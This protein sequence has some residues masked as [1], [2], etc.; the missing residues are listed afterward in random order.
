MFSFLLNPRFEFEE[1]QRLYQLMM[2]SQYFGD[3]VDLFVEKNFLTPEYVVAH[4]NT[5]FRYDPDL[6][7]QYTDV[8]GHY[9]KELELRKK[10]KIFADVSGVLMRKP[11][12]MTLDEMQD[13]LISKI[14]SVRV[15]NPK[16]AEGIR[17]E[18]EYFARKAAPKGIPTGIRV[19]DETLH[20]LKY[21]TLTCIYGYVSSMKSTL[22]LNLTYKAIRS[23]FNVVYITLEVPKEF[24]YFQLLSL[25]SFHEAKSL[26]GPMV[27]YESILNGELSPNDE[28]FLWKVL[29]PDF[30]A[31]A[32]GQ[33][34][35]VGADDLGKASYAE[36]VTL[37]SSFPVNIDMVV[38][39][40]F[41]LLTPY[42]ED[43]NEYMG[44]IRLGRDFV[45]LVVG[46]E[47]SKPKV[48]ILVSQVNQKGY[49]EAIKKQGHYS[50]KAIAETPGLARDAY[51]AIATYLD[52]DLRVGNGVKIG[53]NKNKSG[54]I[55][56]LPQVVPV[57][58]E[59]MCIGY[60]APG[61]ATPVVPYKIGQ[62]FSKWDPTQHIG[63]L[64]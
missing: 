7:L 15:V 60:E 3:F 17:G 25:H 10:E 34:Y 28:K 54:K 8:E 23:G 38:L 48:G 19:L 22:A 16:V 44:A 32:K 41:Q 30:K 57:A 1:R 33:I 61:F 50:L 55:F 47:V 42:I 20:G 64:L 39:D 9:L 26:G 24:M 6:S 2:D 31:K 36:L 11:E 5:R 13:E 62:V 29:E 40:Y 49:E 52:D 45:R 21:G 18:D 14:N 35:F 59:Y 51:Y 53:L 43:K 12:S 46:S 58:Y 63:G 37:C 4:T 56:T 27:K